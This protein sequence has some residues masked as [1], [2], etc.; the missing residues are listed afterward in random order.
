MPADIKNKE[1][2]ALGDVFQG[3]IEIQSDNK[4][5]HF[6]RISSVTGVAMKDILFFDNERGN[7]VE[8]A[9]LGV[10]VGYCPDGVTKRI[11]DCCLQAF[12]TASGK[13]VGLDS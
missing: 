11:W 1:F 3:P 8:V 13:V 9:K 4:V 6:Q 12:P 7:C 5:Y 10:A 2:F